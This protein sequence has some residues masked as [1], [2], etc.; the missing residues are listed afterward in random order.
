MIRPNMGQTR[1]QA[2][3]SSA[4]TR[5]WI[6]LSVPI[7]S[8]M[9][10]WADRPPTERDAIRHVERG[11][12]C[13]VLAL[14]MATHTGTHLDGPVHFL[15]GCPG[16]DAVR[17]ENLMGPA[18]AIEIEGPSAVRWAELR[19]HNMGHSERLLFKTGN[20][21]RGWNSSEFV[22]EFVSLAEDAA[23]LAERKT[24]APGIDYLS[25]GSPEVHRTLPRAGVVIIEGWKL[26]KVRLGVYEFFCLPLR[27][28][29]GDGLA[30]A[31]C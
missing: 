15:P 8:G 4:A 24:L 26:S 22:S 16:T 5:E 25:K 13:T 2:L 9:V 12:M 10:H 28:R 30:L 17:L 14:K 19:K 29:G 18:R 7:Y 20:P 23:N 27:I 21:Q 3:N 31:P 6:D 1:T 11:D